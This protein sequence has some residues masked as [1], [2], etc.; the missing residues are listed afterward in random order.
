MKLKRAQIIDPLMKPR[1]EKPAEPVLS[2]TPHAPEMDASQ[3]WRQRKHNR[4]TGTWVWVP[5]L[6]LAT[7]L[8]VPHK[9]EAADECPTV[10]YGQVSDRV[11]QAQYRLRSFGY[12]LDVDG[13]FGAR[14]LK[15]VQTFQ[16][17]N[18]LL[19]DGVVGPKTQKALGCGLA[20]AVRLNP[21]AP[22]SPP[23][24][25]APTYNGGASGA[26][27]WYSL[28]MQVG[29]TDA[30][31]PVLRCIISRE[32]R[33]IET[34]KNPSSS[35]TGLLQILAR[36]YPGV[37]LYDAETNLRTGLALYQSR[38]WKPWRYSPKP[39]YGEG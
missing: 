39:C 33:G 9:A 16:R 30:Q 5:F 21:P 10:A 13:Q 32:S 19:P 17:Q 35:A 36:Y 15:V 3:F 1:E 38:G 23:A 20:P 28:A 37:D 2:R 14:T 12:V 7:A 22:A 29:W 11:L 24:S 4:R 18:G 26:D 27:Q 34:A 31:W 25:S 6:L 8:F